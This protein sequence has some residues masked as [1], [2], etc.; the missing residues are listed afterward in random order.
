MFKEKCFLRKNNRDL[1]E[2]LHRKISG[3]GGDLLCNL[4]T[5]LLC[6]NN[7]CYRN[8]DDEDDRDKKLIANGYIDCGTNEDLF[9]AIAA[10]RDDTD[11]MQW[12]ISDSDRIDKQTNE[13]ILKKGQWTLCNCKYF[14]DYEIDYELWHK[15][16]VKEI[17][18]HFK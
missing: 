11:N 10:L 14:S 1:W 8:Y 6:A 17:I 18:S 2:I 12:F 7:E 4:S 13:I 9:L 3:R 15:A 16:T 5:M